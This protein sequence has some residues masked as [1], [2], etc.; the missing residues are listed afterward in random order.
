[1]EN[2]TIPPQTALP[3][4]LGQS[5]SGNERF[6]AQPLHAQYFIKDIT[7]LQSHWTRARATKG[8]GRRGIVVFIASFKKRKKF[9]SVPSAVALL[10]LSWSTPVL[11]S[12]RIYVR[13]PRCASSWLCKRYRIALLVGIFLLSQNTGALITTTDTIWKLKRP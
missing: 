13:K 4:S 6:R 12:S 5:N 3:F 1:M 9:R 2:K 8:N 7:I 11:P 10:C